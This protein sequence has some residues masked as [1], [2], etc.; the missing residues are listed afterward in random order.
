MTPPAAHLSTVSATSGVATGDSGARVKV[1]IDV[2][3]RWHD[4]ADALVSPT[5]ICWVAADT[6]VRPA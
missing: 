4:K 6:G 3:D 5:T 1:V 2:F